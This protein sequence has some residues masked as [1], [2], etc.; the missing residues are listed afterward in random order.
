MPVLIVAGFL[1]E[2]RLNDENT[3]G[4]YFVF[5]KPF[6]HGELLSAVKDVLAKVRTRNSG[7]HT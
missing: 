3:I 2:D 1:D 6:A 7:A 5:P 4:E